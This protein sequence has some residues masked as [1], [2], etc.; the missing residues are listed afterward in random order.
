VVGSYFLSVVDL[1]I[2][3]DVPPDATRLFGRWATDRSES[4]QWYFLPWLAAAL[5]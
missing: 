5:V 1:S 3:P 2:L 4:R